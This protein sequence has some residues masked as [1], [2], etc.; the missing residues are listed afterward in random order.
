MPDWLVREQAGQRLAFAAIYG[1]FLLCVTAPYF[2]SDAHMPL[3]TAA[4]SILSAGILAVMLLSAH[5]GTVRFFG[6]SA[7]RT[8]QGLAA[9]YF[10]LVFF[11]GNLD[12]MVGPHRPDR[13]YGFAVSVLLAALLIRFAAA[14]VERHNIRLA[15]KAA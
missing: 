1:V 13:F 4:F 6:P 14:F 12:H 11:L 2:L 10:R 15:E 5:E 3:P 8:M 9:G 7:W